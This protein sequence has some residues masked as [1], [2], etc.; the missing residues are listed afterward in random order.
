MLELLLRR[1]Q[2]EAMAGN[3]DVVSAMVHRMSDGAITE[4]VVGSVVNERGPT[5]RLAQAVPSDVHHAEVGTSLVCGPS[6]CTTIILIV[7]DDYGSCRG[8][9][10][11]VGFGG[12]LFTI[13]N[14]H[15]NA[16]Q[17]RIGPNYTSRISDVN[18][19]GKQLGASSGE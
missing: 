17:P 13:D 15:F 6:L 8:I 1:Q 10:Q 14:L 7:D 18:G 4:F 9:N 16:P 11:L 5:D 2:P 12:Y 3:V 19:E